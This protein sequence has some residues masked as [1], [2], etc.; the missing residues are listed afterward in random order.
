MSRDAGP[1]SLDTRPMSRETCPNKVLFVQFQV[2]FVQ[3]RRVFVRRDLRSAC[4][5]LVW[6]SLYIIF[7]GQ[8]I[9]REAVRN[10]V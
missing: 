8:I 3:Y 6:R 9:I 1:M 7:V 2:I 4:V 5:Y 10:F